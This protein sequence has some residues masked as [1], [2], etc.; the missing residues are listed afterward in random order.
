M[1]FLEAIGTLQITDW[2]LIGGFIVVHI[3]TVALDY[4]VVEN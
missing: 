4:D 2:M 1:N 3:I